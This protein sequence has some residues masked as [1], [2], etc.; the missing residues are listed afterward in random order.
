MVWRQI[1]LENREAGARLVERLQRRVQ[2]MAIERASGTDRNTMQ[3]RM[4]EWPDYLPAIGRYRRR[5]S[6]SSPS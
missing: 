3:E 2:D 5:M 6:R 1:P 4:R